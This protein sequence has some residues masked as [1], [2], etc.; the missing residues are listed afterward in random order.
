VGGTVFLVAQFTLL[1]Q[2]AYGRRFNFDEAAL[3][4]GAKRL[5]EQLADDLRAYGTPV[6]TGIF[7]A[8]VRVLLVNDGPVIFVVDNRET[9]S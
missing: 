1:G 8:H 5:Y 2:T 7:A 9:R 3:P 4:G 6:E